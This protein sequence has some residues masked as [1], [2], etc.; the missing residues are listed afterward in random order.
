[1]LLMAIMLL[2]SWT[3]IGKRSVSGRVTFYLM[4]I[5]CKLNLH[6][7][8]QR[9]YDLSEYE[10]RIKIMSRQKIFFWADDDK[11]GCFSNFYVGPFEID[12]SWWPTTEHYFAA[13]KTEDDSEREAIRKAATPL[14]AKRMGRVVTLRPDWEDV[15]YEVML[16]ALR[17]K[18][19]NHMNLKE[20]LLSTGDALIYEDSPYDKVWGTGQRGGVGTGQ[21]LLGKALMQVRQELGTTPDEF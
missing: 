16:D 11:F 6:T 17:A 9:Y 18:F 3:E 2:A 10:R 14:D 5:L 12:G 19:G 7:P 13:M 21:N 4:E 15:K 20:V 8:Y 1:M